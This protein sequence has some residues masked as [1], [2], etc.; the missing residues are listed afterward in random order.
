M[1]RWR[2]REDR[3]LVQGH[4]VGA[5]QSQSWSLALGPVSQCLAPALFQAKSLQ[6]TANNQRGHAC[7]GAQGGPVWM[8]AQDGPPA[9]VICTNRLVHKVV[10]TLWTDV[11]PLWLLFAQTQRTQESLAVDWSVWT[12]LVCPLP[13]TPQWARW[14]KLG[15]RF[16]CNTVNCLK[17]CD[18]EC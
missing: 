17:A 8:L 10:P 9:E 13:D 4:T 7:A 18:P 5:W 16:C 2:C 1:G 3:W 12:H 14:M 15:A 11:S 6:R